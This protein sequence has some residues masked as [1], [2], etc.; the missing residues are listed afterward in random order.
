LQA[1]KKAQRHGARQVFRVSGS[2]FRVETRSKKLGTRNC[3]R[4]YGAFSSL[5]AKS[6]N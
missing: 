6:L 3:V 2:A 4:A 1:A 5:P